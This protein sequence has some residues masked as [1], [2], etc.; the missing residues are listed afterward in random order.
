MSER[1]RHS[2]ARGE[3]GIVI[4]EMVRQWLVRLWKVAEDLRVKK[5]RV[6]GRGGVCFM[7][8]GGFAE[9]GVV[10]GFERRM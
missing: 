5:S 6:V 8:D 9:V 3:A 2:K 4:M 1:R 7:L 10:F